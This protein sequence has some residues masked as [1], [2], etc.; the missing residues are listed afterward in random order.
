V[1]ASLPHGVN[2]EFVI[3]QCSMCSER[4]GT[5]YSAAQRARP[6]A[7]PCAC[8]T[9]R[10][11]WGPREASHRLLPPSTA[12]HSFHERGLDFLCSA[13]D[14]PSTIIHLERT[15]AFTIEEE[16]ESAP[17]LWVGLVGGDPHLALYF[18]STSHL[19]CVCVAGLLVLSAIPA[20]LDL[21]R[22]Q[23]KPPGGR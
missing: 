8:A 16:L 13:I 1:V 12:Q 21:R 20:R 23:N 17:R 18:V 4:A 14:H 7:L 2:S 15:P 9:R 22:K 6:R 3:D 11:S 5:N 10:E 19:I